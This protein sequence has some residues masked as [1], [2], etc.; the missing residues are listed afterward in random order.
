MNMFLSLGICEDVNICA[1]LGYFVYDVKGIIG[2][3]L[4]RVGKAT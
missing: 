3:S 1:D 4:N 2:Y